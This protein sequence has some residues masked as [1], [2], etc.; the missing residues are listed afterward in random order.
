MVT[1]VFLSMTVLLISHL[2]IEKYFVKTDFEPVS[3]SHSTYGE[4]TANI[5]TFNDNIYVYSTA[6]MF[7]N[8][9][10]ASNCA[11][12]FVTNDGKLIATSKFI[13]RFVHILH[14]FICETNIQQVERISEL[15]NFYS[16][17]C[18]NAKWTCVSHVISQQHPN[19]ARTF[20]CVCCGNIWN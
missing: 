4:I 15:E 19:S 6:V 8:D 20:I 14:R 18:H 7:S 10:T 5:V 17:Y 2:C 9:S 12:L 3:F 1:T 11:V 13:N 16:R